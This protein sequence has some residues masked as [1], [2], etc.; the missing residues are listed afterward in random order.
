[1]I[2]LLIWEFFGAASGDDSLVVHS[3]LV[4]LVTKHGVV[5]HQA[6]HDHV[7]REDDQHQDQDRQ[8]HPPGRSAPG[9]D[10]VESQTAAPD[11]DICDPGHRTEQQEQHLTR[12]L[13]KQKI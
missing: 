8:Q 11:P 4:V 5:R 7:L 12:G 3:V 10:L 6:E 9:P 1:M 2:Y 13:Y